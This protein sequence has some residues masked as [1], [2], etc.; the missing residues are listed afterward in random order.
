MIEHMDF[1]RGMMLRVAFPVIFIFYILSIPPLFSQ[2]LGDLLVGDSSCEKKRTGSEFYEAMRTLDFAEREAM[3]ASELL[4]GNIPCFV[5]KFAEITTVQQDAAGKEHTVAIFVS[6]DYLSVGDS[7]DYFIVPMGPFSA[8]SIS[9]KYAVSLPT[10]KVVDIIYEHSVLKLEPFTYIP[11]GNRNE[12]PDILYDHSKVIQAQMRAAGH[13]PGT[14]VAGTK[15][16]IVISSKLTDTRRTHHV[17]IYGW[18]RLDGKAIQPVNNVHIDTYVDYS[19][20][21]RLVSER[22]LVDGVEYRY[23]DLLK[24]PLLHTLLSNEEQPLMVVRY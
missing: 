19:H 23:S 18:H 8:Q 17:T 5:L 14:F 13:S 21:V 3:I 10:P 2:E 15:K 9:E 7:D 11:R 24:D 22:V 16:D 1:K 20:G 6:P 12:T 4:S